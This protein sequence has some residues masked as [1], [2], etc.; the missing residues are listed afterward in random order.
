[1]TGVSKFAG[2]SIFSALNNV[3]DITLSEDYAA[4]CGITQNELES[5][6]SEHLEVVEKELSRSREE[7]LDSIRQW[8]NGYSWNGKTSVYNPF[9]ALLFFDER[10]F[11]S[12]WFN[13]G[14][15][16]F[17]IELIK[18]RNDVETFLQP[19]QTQGSVFS[20]YDPERLETLPLLF[21][22][23]YLTI[24]K[25]TWED[26]RPTYQLEPPNLEVKESFVNHLFQSYTDLPMEAMT[27]LH[28][29]MRCQIK[30]CDNN[31]LEQSLKSMI[32]RV[33]NKLHIQRESY[34]HSLL[35]VWLNFLGFQAQGE[36]STNIG[37]IDAVWKSSDITIITEVKYSSKKSL[38]K[39][40]DEATKQIYERK[41]YEAYLN[42][43]N[44]IILLS[45]AFSG[46][47]VG[48]RLETLTINN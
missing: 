21:Q 19:V 27:R 5:S 8:Y 33:P 30:T 31:G 48:C 3:K 7:L 34:Y 43:K 47:E 6:F 2:L 1:L 40:L 23:G 9:S 17:L 38:A 35:L 4:L 10:K 42:E 25:I 39:L 32:A 45:I 24:K 26:N 28:T 29:N 20:S 12:Y 46:K 36:V 41:Y 44:K 13:T 18:K 22:T 15:P 11:M 16:T 14:T 37:I